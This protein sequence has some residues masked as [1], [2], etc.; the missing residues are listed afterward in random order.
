[1]ALSTQAVL[2]EA[3]GL[4]DRLGIPRETV[5]QVLLKSWGASYM[6]ERKL[7]ALVARDYRPGFL[8]DLAWKDLGLALELGEQAGAPMEVGRQAW[9]LYA[10]A[11]EAGLGGL[12]SAGLLALLE[13]R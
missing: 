4:A 3:L 12:D 6:L 13:P 7:A 9:R 10:R 11:R 2:C 5:G 8:V 1:V